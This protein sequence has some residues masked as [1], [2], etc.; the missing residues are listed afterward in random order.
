VT[1]DLL[2]PGHI[3][4]SKD[5]DEKLVLWSA[6]KCESDEF[7][8]IVDSNEIM[9]VLE[10]KKSTS[11]EEFL[12]SEWENGAYFVMTSSGVKGWVGSGWVTSV[13]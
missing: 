8:E 13:S 9:I 2:K 10:A 3:V 4:V 11:S 1:E 7:Y 6:Y 5:K 12:N